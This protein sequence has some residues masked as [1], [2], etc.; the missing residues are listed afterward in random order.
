MH[1][2]QSRRAPASASAWA[3]SGIW[4]GRAADAARGAGCGAGGGH[5]M[6]VV[7]MHGAGP[8]PYGGEATYRAVE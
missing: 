1:P 7:R 3:A 5:R 6:A 4:A 8:S 2:E